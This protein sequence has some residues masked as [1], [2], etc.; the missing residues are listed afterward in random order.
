MGPNARVEIHQNRTRSWGRYDCF[1]Y[2][3]DSAHGE[4][5]SDFRCAMTR[6]G[7]RVEARRAIREYG[8][9]RE[10]DEPVGQL[11]EVVR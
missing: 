9:G 7:A 1:L 5:W 8:E 6:W 2:R 10:P 11:V 3:D 4:D